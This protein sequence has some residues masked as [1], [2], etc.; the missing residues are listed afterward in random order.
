MECYC[1]SYIYLPLYITLRVSYKIESFYH[2]PPSKR[3]QDEKSLKSMNPPKRDIPILTNPDLWKHSPGKHRTFSSSINFCANAK[4]SPMSFHLS[5][6][7]PT[8][9]SIDDLERRTIAYNAPCGSITFNPG[10][11]ANSS[12]ISFALVFNSDTTPSKNPGG[13]SSILGNAV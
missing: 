4:V 3:L 13:I 8:Y 2:R 9:K 6:S 12:T 1:F 5:Y 10:A 11:W 7:K